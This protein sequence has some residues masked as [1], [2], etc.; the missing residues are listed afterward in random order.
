MSAH[1]ASAAGLRAGR[2]A[3]L[4]DQRT[5]RTKAVGGPLAIR[6]QDAAVGWA[7][8]AGQAGHGAAL[9]LYVQAFTTAYATWD[10]WTT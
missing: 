3:A 7:Q 6:A 4:H 9:R 5:G 8:G 2:A 1:P 10:G